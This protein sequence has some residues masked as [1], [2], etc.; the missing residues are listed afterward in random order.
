M[1][2]IIKLGLVMGVLFCAAIGAASAQ[3]EFSEDYK[4]G[5][6]DGFYMAMM[7][8]CGANMQGSSLVSLY[9]D[10]EGKPTEETLVVE[11]ETM[12]WSDYYNELAT[13]FNE[14]TVINL[15]DMILQ[16][17]GPDD[18]RTQQLLLPELPLIS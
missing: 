11:N 12:K 15:N 14:E 9:N 2:E 1:K 17:Y 4:E 10:L 7:Y 5:Y 3:E 18:N 8:L 13:Q 6:K 16:I